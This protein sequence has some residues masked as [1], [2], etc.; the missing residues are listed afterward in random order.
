MECCDRA[1]IQKDSVELS[2]NFAL[3]VDSLNKSN[4][5][6]LFQVEFREI[7]RQEKYF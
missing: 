2:R 5:L 1:Y 7:E 3:I 4:N 6:F